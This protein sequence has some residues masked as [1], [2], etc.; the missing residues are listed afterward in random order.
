M[1]S[2][3]VGVLFTDIY[4]DYTLK[5]LSWANKK[6]DCSA[7][8]EDLVHDIFLQLLSALRKK[9]EA[10]I[11]N[12]TPESLNNY[13]WKIAYYT[14]CKYLRSKANKHQYQ[15]F[16]VDNTSMN[17]ECAKETIRNMRESIS[18]LNYLH[19]ESMIMRYIEK[20]SSKD[21]ATKLNITEK[22]VNQLLYE[23][24]NK[25]SKG[26]K[27]MSNHTEYSYRPDRLKMSLLGEKVDY[28]DINLIENSLTKQN[29]CI[30]CYKTS[31]NID[32]LAEILGIPK[33]YIEDDLDWL[34]KKEFIIKKQAKYS[35][36]FFINDNDFKRR[37]INVFYDNKTGFSDKMIEQF[38]SK[39][40]EIKAIG[41]HGSENPI[42]KLL[43]YLIFSFTH[44]TIA[45]E[46][47]GEIKYD[48]DWPI[49]SDGGRYFPIGYY[50]FESNIELNPKYVERY[51]EISNWLSSGGIIWE[52]C[53][54]KI[55]WVGT[56]NACDE[57]LLQ[58]AY[59]S[60]D[61]NIS[62]LRK[63]FLKASKPD[64]DIESLTENEKVTLSRMLSYEW[65]SV[66][67]ITK[68]SQ[69]PRIVPN[70]Y[71]F[72]EAQETELNK[73][74]H[75]IYCEIQDEIKKLAKDVKKV[76]EQV[77]PPQL[78]FFKEY[79]LYNYLFRSNFY[80]T[81]F[82]FYDKKLYIPKNEKECSLLTLGV[83]HN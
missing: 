78:C 63:T 33:S 4:N 69:T 41:F 67:N 77:L 54:N 45:H 9:S 79:C 11:K 76:I 6:T 37:L 7:E 80:T 18:N 28:P 42:E 50:D 51:N 55:K 61:V 27:K 26:K 1:Q 65:F 5:L 72:S 10:E 75:E 24:R 46:C 35:T 17:D 19:R 58:F 66:S 70:F 21:I 38:I 49:R 15:H 22:H 3:C 73:I 8:A 81:G 47:F 39:Q 23:A 2:T 60:L 20:K 68:S 36:I 31:K 74:F 48:L 64:F 29:I 56:Y 40:A 43:W 30:S 16:V 52:D 32:E 12:E 13:I 14:W 57:N 82:A 34:V 44:F 59:D 62:G 71:V 53:S 25:I 83:I